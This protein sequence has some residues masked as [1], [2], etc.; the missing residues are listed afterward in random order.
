LLDAAY[1][2]VGASEPPNE[3]ILRGQLSHKSQQIFEA[4]LSSYDGSYA[5]VL[6]HVQ[7]ERYFISRRYRVGAVTVG[8]Q[9]SVDASERQITM[10]R[11]LQS[12]PASLQ[13]GT[14]YEAKGGHT[15]PRG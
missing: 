1:R 12:L 13:A 9:L 3:W 7:V 15:H 6:K 11:S 5:D 14:L 8:P 2:R 10:D 4:L